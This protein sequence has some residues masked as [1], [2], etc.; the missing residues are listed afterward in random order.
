MASD[1][2][3]PST[4]LTTT[5]ATS[6]AVATTKKKKIIKVKKRRP[7]RPQVDPA[8]FKTPQGDAT[9]TLYNIWYNKWSGSGST[10]GYSNQTPQHAAGGRCNLA[11]DTG[12]TRADSVQGS[13]FC[14][15]FA[16]GICPRGKE[17]DYLHRLPV[18]TDIPNP[19]VDCFGRDKFADY[20]DDMGGVGSFMRL[21]RTLYIGRIAE[22]DD[23]EEVVARHFA[24]WGD[25]E[26]CL[27]LFGET[28]IDANDA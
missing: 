9:G 2:E 6:S 5:D 23:V 21:N 1:E 22:S 14:L 20:R 25:I 24:E 12:Y 7:A 11:R 8:T 16:R 19:N 10:D 4:A 27:I 18:V 28:V 3:T 15:F 13:P 17:C 26:V